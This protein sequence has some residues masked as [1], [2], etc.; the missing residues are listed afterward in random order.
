MRPGA[1]ITVNQHYLGRD[2][3]IRS[4]MP[5]AAAHALASCCDVQLV[6]SQP[7]LSI[8]AVSSSFA[9]TKCRRLQMYVVELTGR[10][11]S[12]VK[13]VSKPFS[14][15]HEAEGLLRWR[16]EVGI[17]DVSWSGDLYPRGG[18]HGDAF[19]ITTFKNFRFRRAR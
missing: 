1:H 9:I 7:N 13:M 4:G 2:F 3:C 19:W 14:E 10:R 8:S 12:L 15:G 6:V 17:S 16:R 5:I 18:S 11:I